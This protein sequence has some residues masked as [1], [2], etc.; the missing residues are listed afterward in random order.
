MLLC[1]ECDKK[2]EVRGLTDFIALVRRL[3]YTSARTHTTAY[4]SG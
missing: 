3:V 1:H 2:Y 4:L